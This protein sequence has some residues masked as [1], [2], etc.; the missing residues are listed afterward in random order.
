MQ[1]VAADT[2]RIEIQLDALASLPSG[3]SYQQQH[4]RANVKAY[5]KKAPP[6]GGAETRAPTVVIE[7]SCDSLQQLY[8]EQTIRA[9]SLQRQADYMSRQLQ[10]AYLNSIKTPVERRS[11]GIWP[12]VLIAVAV[13]GLMAMKGKKVN[14]KH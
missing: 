11:N 7:A 4:G 1:P 14:T 13:V 9:D 6:D 10:E 2:A 5:V 8:M 3:A 12:W